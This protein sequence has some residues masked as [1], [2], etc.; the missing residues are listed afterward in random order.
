MSK[1]Y[2]D[3]LDA[4]LDRPIAFN[5][6]FKK[7]TGSTNAALLLSQAFYW[8]KRT[9][10]QDGWF[11]KTRDEWCE[12]TGLTLEELDGARTKC[13]TAGV[14]EETLKGVPAT[15]HYRV[16]KPKVYELLGVQFG[17]IPQSS[18]SDLPQIG[19]NPESGSYPNFNKESETPSRITTEREV[20]LD[21]EGM[22]VSEAKQVPTL[23]MYWKATNFWPGDLLWE[24]I[25][26]TILENHLTEEKIRV[27]ATEWVSRSYKI[28]NVKGIL[29]WAVNGIPASKNSP[30]PA[31]SAQAPDKFAALIDYVDQQETRS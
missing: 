26:K 21:F 16:N 1:K 30:A 10:D 2:Y 4:I 13:K 3:A 7:I 31:T 27:A 24:T 29:E 28:G 22:N 23:K 5:P 11:Y 17:G 18:F 25:H 14:I 6:S 19:G 8:S 9:N 12:E 15:V 20:S